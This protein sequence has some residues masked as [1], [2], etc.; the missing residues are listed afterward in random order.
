MWTTNPLRLQKQEASASQPG[1]AQIHNNV[2]NPQVLQPTKKSFA[3][4]FE[5]PPDDVKAF[6]KMID[7]DDIKI[8]DEPS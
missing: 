2:A 5:Q 4:L 3:G 1:A 7:S 6:F 8:L